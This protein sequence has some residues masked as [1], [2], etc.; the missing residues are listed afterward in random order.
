[1]SVILNML[2][3][4]NRAKVDCQ[5]ST[6]SHVW[7]CD[8]VWLTAIPKAQFTFNTVSTSFY[9]TSVQHLI[10]HYLLS[11]SLPTLPSV[12][13]HCWLCFVCTHPICYDRRLE[14]CSRK[15]GRIAIW[16]RKTIIVLITMGV[17]LADL[18]SFI[19]GEYLL[20][21]KAGSLI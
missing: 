7:L 4:D 17:W 13:L 3:F 9:V 14:P 20:Q 21:I 6:V 18:A 10:P 8:S 5:V 15:L 19:Y 1:M 2:G 11:S 12:P 16:H